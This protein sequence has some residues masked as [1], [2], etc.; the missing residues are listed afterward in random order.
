MSKPR[1]QTYKGDY[2]S[3]EKEAHGHD[4]DSY[5]RFLATAPSTTPVQ[6]SEPKP[7]KVTPHKAT[8]SRKK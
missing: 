3:R 4:E 8:P 7:A 6:D 2:L 5:Q 1:P